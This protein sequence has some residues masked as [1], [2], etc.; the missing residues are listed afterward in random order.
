MD[1]LYFWRLSDEVTVMQAALLAIGED[2]SGMSSN[3]EKWEVYRRPTGYE[4]IKS[5]LCNALLSRSV[6][7]RL[8]P[9]SV[10]DKKALRFIDIVD[11]VD[12]QKSTV[13]INSVR[14]WL[15]KKGVESD[16]Y[17]LSNSYVPSYLDVNHPRYAPKLAAAI[18]AWEAMEDA[19]LYAG[20][21]PKKA[22]EAWLK[23][24]AADFDLTLEDGRPNRNGITEA[25]KVANWQ[26]LGGAPKTPS[27]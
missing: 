10:Y 22:L 1:D 6:S 27:G 11:S 8:V 7:G 26:P 14:D 3:V 23:A 2:P 17:S 16:F 21:S 19:S 25:A 12:V 15:K 20:K 13:Y 4:A 24:H 5:A 18:K 9:V